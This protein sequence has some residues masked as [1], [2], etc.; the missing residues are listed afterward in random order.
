MK[1]ILNTRSIFILGLALGLIW[2][3]FVWATPANADGGGW[4][5]A[6]PTATQV[7]AAGTG[8]P[9]DLLLTPVPS[10]VIAPDSG[11]SSVSFLDELATAQ[12]ESMQT[13]TALS[14]LLTPAA[15][16][17]TSG[18][19]IPPMWPVIGLVIVIPILA[20]LAYQFLRRGGPG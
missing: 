1:Q 10:A 7:G 13:A 19:G 3:G 4:P 2:A 5:T 8:S 20:F 17:S 14:I 18:G 9:F 15:T 16:Q 11:G 12:I 6:T